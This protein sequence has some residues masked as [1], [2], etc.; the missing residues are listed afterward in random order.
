MEITRDTFENNLPTILSE[1]DKSQF[2][3][4]DCEFTGLNQRTK[5]DHLLDSLEERYEKRLGDDNFVINQFG[6]S[7][8]VK[9]E[10][11]ETWKVTVF[12]FYVFPSS[13]VE[14]W[15][16]CQSG[17]LRYLAEHGFDFNAWIGKGIPFLNYQQ[18]EVVVLERMKVDSREVYLSEKDMEFLGKMIDIVDQWDF[19]GESS[20]VLPPCSPYRRKLLYQEIPKRF[21][22]LKLESV[23]VGN[24]KSI[25]LTRMT[26]EELDEVLKEMEQQVRESVLPEVGFRRIIDA[27]IASK[28]PIVGHNMF[29]DLILIYNQFIE[30]L[31]PSLDEFKEKISSLFP[32]IID[33]RYLA[34]LPTIQPLFPSSVLSH[35]YGKIQETLFIPE[36]GFN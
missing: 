17:S 1:I 5:E 24:S 34:H 32:C 20:A 29:L 22:D 25:K 35:L 26:E 19:D 2:I 10:D 8:F 27:I 23:Q 36:I 3:S 31:P 14:D 16:L 4:I 12:N 9:N 6:L 7:C 28:K 13:A 11:E 30:Q 15:F 21:T 33:T 18:E